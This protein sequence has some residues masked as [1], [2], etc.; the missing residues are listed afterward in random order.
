MQL[1]RNVA[2]C[3][4]VGKTS[5]ER[6]GPKF[7]AAT[8]VLLRPTTSLAKKVFGGGYAAHLCYHKML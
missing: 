3:L 1:S 7:F 2:S 8:D 5:T 4:S 6:T